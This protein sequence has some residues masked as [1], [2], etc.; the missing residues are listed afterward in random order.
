MKKIKPRRRRLRINSPVSFGVLCALI[1][2]LIGG[3]TFGL[4]AGVISPAVQ[5]IRE[6]NATPTPEPTPTPVVVTPP[7]STPTP[8]PADPGATND[9][10]ATADPNVT[11]DPNATVDPNATPDP[12]APVDQEPTP[13]GRLAGHVI[14]I[15]AAKSKGA[16][17]KGVSTGTA[18]YKINFA[19]A[20]AVR[21]LLEAEGATVVM[22]RTSNSEVVEPA[23]RIRI[24]NKSEAELVLSIMC[25]YIDAGSTRGAQ[26]IVPKKNGNL[27]ACD[28]LAEAV[29]KAY[30]KA[31]NMPTREVGDSA[32]RHLT[33]WPVLN[34]IDKPVAALVLGHISNKTDDKNLNDADFIQR[35]AQGIVNGIIAYLEG[36]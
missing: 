27:S 1:L 20:D 7:P 9:P 32:I 24:V 3:A 12:N 23:D 16:K 10:N 25:N 36:K 18:E 17:Y 26:M 15:D 6:A 30:T 11:A 33:T 29:L 34:G 35:G 14:A 4:A 8:E 5:A 2:L 13:T 28:A 21:E 19:F 31:T 22:T